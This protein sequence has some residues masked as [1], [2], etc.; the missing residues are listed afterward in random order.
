M[1]CDLTRTGPAHPACRPKTGT[2]LTFMLCFQGLDVLMYGDTLVE[3][4]RG[5]FLGEPAA[6]AQ[7][8]ADVFHNQFGVKYRA[9]AL[10]IAGDDPLSLSSLIELNK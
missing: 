4:W 6:R 8:C 1:R 5:T 10:G 9:A 3:A 7:G 2:I